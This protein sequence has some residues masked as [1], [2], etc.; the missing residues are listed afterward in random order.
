M[1]G[2]LAFAGGPVNNYVT[3][4]IAAMAGRLRDQPGTVG[5]VTA[6]GWYLTKHSLGLWST[7]P[8]AGGFRWESAQAGVDPLPQRSPASDHEGEATVETYTVV[9]DRDGDP[10][11]GILAL[12]TGD[13]RRA[14]GNTT[15]PDTMTEL[16]L[17]EGCGRKARLNPDGRTELR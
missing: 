12:L 11:L 5:L 9:H 6:L 4:S 3:H 1:T 10:E 15:D 8:P 14:W 7:T 17:E 16:T 2:G 13:G